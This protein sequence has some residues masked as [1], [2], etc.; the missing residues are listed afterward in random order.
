MSLTH[1]KMKEQK[2]FFHHS[3][4]LPVNYISLQLLGGLW[5]SPTLWR[6][7]SLQMWVHGSQER[8]VINHPSANGQTENAHFLLTEK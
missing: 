7:Q 2:M 8:Q 6:T 1:T 4:Q 3:I 5:L